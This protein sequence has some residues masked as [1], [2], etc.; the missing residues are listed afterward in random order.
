MD[1]RES[2]R[3]SRSS[4]RSAGT[5][6]GLAARLVRWLG[7][8]LAGV[9]LLLV[10]LAAAGAIYQGMASA[11]DAE[12]NPPPGRM[13]DLGGH[14]LHL[15]CEGEGAPVVVLDTVLGGSSLSWARVQPQ[16]AGTTRVCSF[17]RPGYGWSDPGPS[18]RTSDRI[19]EELRL[20]LEKAELP[21]PYLLVGA[22][23]GGCNMRLFA[24]RH[25]DRVSG[26]VLVD[27]AHEDQIR[28]MPRSRDPAVELGPLRLFRIAV[29]LGILRIAGMPVGEASMGFLP[30]GLQDRARMVG[31]RTAVV[32]AIYEETAALPESFSELREA[33]T[34]AGKTPFGSRPLVVLTHAEEKPLQGDEAEA[35][36]TW[37]R[38]QAELAAQSTRGRQ[39][40]V[41]PSGHFIAV[42]QPA[43]VAEAIREVVA[44]VRNEGRPAPFS[45]SP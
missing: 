44:A 40:I 28:R 31:M 12:R 26:L 38:M 6:R 15:W 20:A 9:I 19:V 7:W 39:V 18:P 10:I 4:P 3:T 35:Y 30:A 32:D 22:S 33:V 16:V 5:G 37:L 8:S 1:T 27:S 21:K 14:R 17:D 43:R 2:R 45:S 42:D 36:R 24:L 11:R 41:K 29:R 25:P 23:F 34:T 13:V